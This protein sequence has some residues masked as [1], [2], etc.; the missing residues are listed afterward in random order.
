MAKI[1]GTG[2]FSGCKEGWIVDARVQDNTVV[3]SSI[4]MRPHLHDGPHIY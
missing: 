3:T 2:L 1:S 4:R